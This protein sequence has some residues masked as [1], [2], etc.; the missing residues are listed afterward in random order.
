MNVNNKDLAAT[1]KAHQEVDV[2][3]IN[4][5]LQEF[6]KS[7][8]SIKKSGALINF[9]K[10]VQSIK[11]Q[12]P[13]RDIRKALAM[14][15]DP[16]AQFRKNIEALNSQN[17]LD[18]FRKN[19]NSALSNQPFIEFQKNLHTLLKTDPLA[20][21]RKNINKI[22][23]QTDFTAIQAQIGALVNNDSFKYFQINL[24][25]ILATSDTYKNIFLTGVP[26][27]TFEEAFN[28]ITTSYFEAVSLD[29]EKQEDVVV[30]VVENFSEKA[31]KFG[32]SKLSLEFYLNLLIALMF[33]VYS[34]Q[35]SQETETRISN[36]LSDAQELIIERLDNLIENKNDETYYIVLRNVNLREAPSNKSTV[37]TVLYRNQ[38]VRLVQRKSKWIQVEYYDHILG[39]HLTGWCYKKYLTKMK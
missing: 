19:I 30:K 8:D 22:I 7:I 14:Y 28:E 12:D 37:K 31:K 20:D 38:K 13:F 5:I 35:L 9:Q 16:F 3:Q 6:Q 24:K 4:S 21:I 36:Q 26:A 18:E 33:F 39:V 29:G 2:E 32:L 15:Q 27:N 17:P 10:Q 11:F 1:V 25:K 23:F 34:Q